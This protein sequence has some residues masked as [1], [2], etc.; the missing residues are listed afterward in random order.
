MLDDAAASVNAAKPV[1]KL[2]HHKI[3]DEA[4]RRAAGERSRPINGCAPEV[5]GERTGAKDRR[6]GPIFAYCP[7]RVE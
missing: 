7:P 5:P 6:H 1:L 3:N 2:F 4:I